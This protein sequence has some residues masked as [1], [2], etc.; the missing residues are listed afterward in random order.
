MM[1]FLLVLLDV[2]VFLVD[3][4]FIPE[5][6]LPPAPYVIPVL[7][8]AYLLPPS[9]VA[10]IT[11]LSIAFQLT[12][13]SFHPTPL[14]L[15][16]LYAASIGLVGFLAAA[17]SHRTRREAATAAQLDSTITSM[18]D[19][20]V[21]YGRDGEILRMNPAA[22]RMLG[23]SEEERRLPLAG[24]LPAVQAETEERKPIEPEDTPPARALRGETVRGMV[25]VLHRGERTI[26]TSASASPIYTPDGTLLGAVVTLVDI[27]AR[28]ELE[29]QRDDLVRAISH[30]LRN[31]LTAVQGQAQ[32]LQRLLRGMGVEERMVRSAEAIT[33]GAQR[34]NAMILDLVESTRLEAGQLRL[35]KRPTN[36]RALLD[37]LLDRSSGV[38]EVERIR[39][40]IPADLPPV[41]ADPDRLE[42][43][44]T[45]LLTNAL[46]YSSKGSEVV[47]EAVATD[48][49]VTT[50][51]VDRGVG[52]SEEDLPHI[53]E[54]F[55]RAKGT[56]KTEGLG[57]GLYI[58]RMLIEAH[59]GRIWAESHEGEGSRF[60]FTIPVAVSNR[61]TDTD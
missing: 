6:V 16:S 53:F 29:E 54:R 45:N 22:E 10:A 30:D 49:W 47:V 19:A 7:I 21:I 37:G 35:T 42:R 57:M 3:I 12:A 11:A 23:L 25:V 14:W 44:F 17:L 1:L 52:I 51:V 28:H 48:G 61:G 55:Y 43:V 8:S 40:Q 46:K 33:I 50:S 27:T 13:A 32:L 34:M 41:D 20:V 5:N 59:G 56:R 15:V 4:Y 60:S 18:A 26:W 31:P 24:R 9:L 39:V 38:M 36:L 2:G 58:A